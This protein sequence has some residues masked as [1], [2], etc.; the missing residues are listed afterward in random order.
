[1]ASFNFLNTLSNLNE[2]SFASYF[3]MVS[4]SVNSFKASILATSPSTCSSLASSISLQFPVKHDSIFEFDASISFSA[5]DFCFIT[6]ATSSLSFN[7][8]FLRYSNSLMTCAYSKFSFLYVRTV[9]PCRPFPHF[10][11]LYTSFAVMFLPCNLT[12]RS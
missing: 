11:S 1:M 3:L 10:S 8:S 9:V 6:E 7:N 2:N 5:R 12:P 4:I